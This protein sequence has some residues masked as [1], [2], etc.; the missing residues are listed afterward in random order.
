M[1]VRFSCLGGSY[2]RLFLA[3]RCLLHQALE[4]NQSYQLVLREQLDKLGVLARR[5]QE[6]RRVLQQELALVTNRHNHSL[7]RQQV[8]QFPFICDT[9]G[10][11]PGVV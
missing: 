4:A 9:R 8:M 6:R 7:S 10:D 3:T 5:N 1:P 11:V 2:S